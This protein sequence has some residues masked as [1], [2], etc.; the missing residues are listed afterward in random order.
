MQRNFKDDPSEISGAYGFIIWMEKQLTVN[1]ALG[2]GN[3]RLPIFSDNIESLFGLSKSHGTGEVRDANRIAL[4]L[5]AFCGPVNRESARMVMDVTVKEQQE[6]ESKLLSLT[7]QR[8]NFLPNPGSLNDSL[9]TESYGYLSIMP[10]PKN[11]GNTNKIVDI[12][13]SYDNVSGPINE[14]A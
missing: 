6:I 3:I 8:R 10:V 9:L 1:S 4:R 13:D 7:R 14:V 5:P 2:M 12:K 11:K